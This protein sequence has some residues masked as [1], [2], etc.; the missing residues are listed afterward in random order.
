MVD[1]YQYMLRIVPFSAFTQD[2]HFGAPIVFTLYSQT[3]AD[4]I[5]YICAYG[6]REVSA[7]LPMTIKS[8]P[9]VYPPSDLFFI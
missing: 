5:H 8:I 1:L 2:T 7:I 9:S 3:E 4:Q 6:I